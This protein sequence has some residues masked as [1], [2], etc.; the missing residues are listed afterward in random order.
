MKIPQGYTHPVGIGKGSFSTVYR[1]FQKKLER[2]VALKIIPLQQVNR[3]TKVQEEAQ[4]LASM[5][6]SCVPHLY[7]IQRIG[8]TVTLVME[9]IYGIPLSLLVQQPLSSP[10]KF[11]LANSIIHALTQLHSGSVVHRDL[12][13]DNI[14]VTPSGQMFFVDFGFSILKQSTNSHNTLKGTPTY[15]APELWVNND[16]INFTKTD[17][18]SLGVVLKD[19]LGEELPG[20]AYP[21]LHTDPQQRPKDCASFERN[22]VGNNFN[23]D[24]NA[25]CVKVTDA[26]SEYNARL[27][28]D[29]AQEL[30]SNGRK[31]EAYTLL[32]ESL[33]A[34]PDNPAALDFLQTHFSLPLQSTTHKQF[35]V[36]A[37]VVIISVAALAGAYLVGMRS[38]VSHS[39]TNN[40]HFTNNQENQHHDFLMMPHNLHNTH[41]V[42]VAL[43]SIAETSEFSGTVS[44]LLPRSSG[45]LRIDNR[46]I[47]TT[48]NNRFVGSL[49][50][51]THRIEW[52]DSTLQQSFGETINLLPFSVKSISVQRFA[53][54]QQSIK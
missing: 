51:G 23:S 32:T 44:I 25:M 9:W 53:Y 47:N 30:Y 50:A 2:H 45:A 20:I 40:H 21:L 14:I 43:R 10:I 39:N 1:A 17:L 33:D 34:W 12:K 15:M 8:K 37:T 26:T 31:E 11:A 3:A 42:P 4:T 41:R 35:F 52:F 27:F 5:R 38:S 13:P 28:F 48:T 29:G 54:V 19:L 36:W 7:D 16:N 24:T 46:S 49:T 22:W 18:Y 6:L